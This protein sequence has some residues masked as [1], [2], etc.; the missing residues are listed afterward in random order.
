[1]S[2]AARWEKSG[3]LLACSGRIS[4]T[5]LIGVFE[6]VGKDPRFNQLSY[7]IID[8]SGV[9]EVEIREGGSDMITA[10]DYAHA[11]ANRRLLRAFVASS[12]NIAS[13]IRERITISAFPERLSF[14]SSLGA[15]RAW[16]EQCGGWRKG[17]ASPIAS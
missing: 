14:F 17:S 7:L 1:M 16:I 8:C 12:P 15:A 2:L 4:C 6:S 13:C 10:I 5:E 11:L 9:T 3:V